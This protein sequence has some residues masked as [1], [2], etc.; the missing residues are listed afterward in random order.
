MATLTKVYYL[1]AYLGMANAA[2]NSQISRR[3]TQGLKELVYLSKVSME[4]PGDSVTEVP[5]SLDTRIVLP[6]NIVG[7]AYRHRGLIRRVITIFS[8]LSRREGLWDTVLSRKVMQWVS[9]I[10]EV[11]LTD[12]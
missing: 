11:G 10:E 4:L 1:S 6:L 5:F 7:W 2:P 9:E 12:E 8:K 3:L